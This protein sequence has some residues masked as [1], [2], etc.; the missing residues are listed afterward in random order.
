MAALF[1]V[2]RSVFS[3]QGSS[4]LLNRYRVFGSTELTQDNVLEEASR[5]HSVGLC[6]L[7]YKTKLISK[8]P[9]SSNLRFQ[10]CLE[11]GLKSKIVRRGRWHRAP[12]G[13][14][15]TNLR[16]MRDVVREGTSESV[17]SIFQKEKQ[18]AQQTSLNG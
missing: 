10:S 14:S 4:V 18:Q 13:A 15:P 11:T 12:A 16:H 9:S 3:Q 2:S 17:P 1:L 7:A 6:L 5:K 8:V